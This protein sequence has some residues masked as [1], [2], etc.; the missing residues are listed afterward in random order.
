MLINPDELVDDEGRTVAA[1]AKTKVYKISLSGYF[2]GGVPEYQYKLASGTNFAGGVVTDFE[3]KDAMLEYTITVPPTPSYTT[4]YSGSVMATDAKGVTATATVGIMLN[5]APLTAGDTDSDGTLDVNNGFLLLGTQAADRATSLNAQGNVHEACAK[6]DTCVLDAFQD[7]GDFTYAVK[8][9]KRL[10]LN[11]ATR[12]S[13]ETTD[14]GDVKLTGMKS[15]WNA[16]LNTPAHSNVTVTLTATDGNGLTKD[17]DL[18]VQVNG[19]PTLTAAGQDINGMSYDVKNTLRI[20]GSTDATSA[21]FEDAEGNSLTIAA[22][23]DKSNVASV[24]NSDGILVT[25]LA[26]GQTAT[27]T[28]TATEDGDLGQKA[29]VK[30]KVKVTQVGT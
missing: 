26:L 29:E 18:V 9:Q 20:T 25:G 28:V 12:V 11:D 6:V 19:A 13:W 3:I 5:R 4:T 22:V 8:A 15:T 2:T 21:L 23:S 10:G 16:D 30:F 1:N 24:A 17:V 14:S 27:I 7:D